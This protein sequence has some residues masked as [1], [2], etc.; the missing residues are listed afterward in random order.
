VQ[1][2]P[3]TMHLARV[4][5]SSH[6]PPWHVPGVQHSV[7]LE[8]LPP[9]GW[10]APTAWAQGARQCP[11][12]SQDRPEQQVCPFC[13]HAPPSA[14]QAQTLFTQA[15]PVQQAW[16]AEQ[17]VPAALHATTGFDFTQ[18]A[19]P[20]TTLNAKTRRRALELGRTD[21]NM[22]SREWVRG[23]GKEPILTAFGKS[24]NIG[25]P[26]KGISG[27]NVF[28]VPFPIRLKSPVSIC[29]ERGQ[30]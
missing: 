30:G 22:S 9:K 11:V 12:P 8:H 15:K 16:A 4:E 7:S 6:T 28:G 26:A 20:N 17:A 21:G 13:P 5:G 3:A 25:V 23:S 1:A 14:P 24:V 27:G 19:M 18:P 10:Q 2:L 29:V